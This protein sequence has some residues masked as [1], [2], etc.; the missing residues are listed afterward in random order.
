VLAGRDWSGQ[1]SESLEA[2]LNGVVIGSGTT[3][4]SQGFQLVTLTGT[5]KAGSNTLEFLG[6]SQ[7]TD[8]TAFIE[9]VN[10]A[11]VPETSTWA[12][13]ILGFATLG[14]W[15]YRGRNKLAPGGA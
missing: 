1:G 2:I 3:S 15:G 7:L 8:Q 9:N 6:L 14:F 12:M 11:A 10:V 5:L 13:M 4:D